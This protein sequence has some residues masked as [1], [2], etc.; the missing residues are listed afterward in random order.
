MWLWSPT[1]A[2]FWTIQLLLPSWQ[3]EDRRSI[4]PVV[5]IRNGTLVGRQN[6][7]Y[8]Q[9][10]FLGIPYAQP[11]VGELRYQSP[12][13]LNESWE[14]PRLAK[15][16]GFWCH[17]APLS[18]PGYTQEGFPHEENEDCLTINVVRPTGVTASAQLPV[19]VYIYG[20]GLQEGGSA[21]QRYNM[22]F[23]V[24]ESVKMGTPTIGVSFNYRV[25]GFGFLSGRAVND[26]GVANLG[27]YDQRKAL[28]WINE[29]IA[30]FGGDPTQVTLQGE[31][32]GA[33][34]V[35]YHLLA[36]GGRDDRLFRAA[37]A[38][39][40]GPLSS[41]ALIPLDEQELMYQDVLNATGCAATTE[42]LD[43]LRQA[44]VESLKASFQGR[45]FFPVIDG[46]FITG[47]PSNAL[48]QGKFVKVPLLIGSNLNEGTGYIAS[49]SFGAVNRPAD[50]RAVIT[51]FGP[52]KYLTKRTLAE[53]VNRYLQLPVEEVQA[54]LG[55]VRMSP[56]PQYGCLYG[57]STFY[58]GDY[59]VNAPKRYSAQMWAEHG[60][61]VYSYLFD[62]VP[63]GVSPQVL[64]AAHFQEIAFVFRNFAGVGYTIPP[65]TSS[66]EDVETQLRD[67][68]QLMTRMWLSFI[69]TLSPN[70]HQSMSVPSCLP[71]GDSLYAVPD[72]E[73]EWPVYQ[74][75]S[76]NNLVIRLE[77]ATIE[78]DTW[79]S[80]AIQRII[81]AFDEYKF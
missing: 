43:C 37:I 42:T 5:T 64:G 10:F 55:T 79:R 67:A 63:N 59:L 73:V 11:P 72:L 51:G 38:E 32:S 71:F 41:A 66:D 7:H 50:L 1:I 16:Y 27:L 9:D 36:Y 25:S 39:S 20:G 40:G 8:N 45:F 12:Q 33:L 58:I 70:N 46:K 6:V 17:S 19:L 68:S 22:S 3:L 57:H 21:D 56:G 44:P 24:R 75:A 52:G 30:A 47:Y 13:S 26:F 54:D 74:K 14:I 77:N 4:E 18:L 80:K 60:A 31:S 49:G 35:G 34:S 69:T 23:L 62:V 53:I 81:D 28:H 2:C 65:L 29:N 78:A 61:A 48:K 15:T 76:S